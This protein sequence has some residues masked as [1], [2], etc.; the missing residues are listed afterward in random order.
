MDKNNKSLLRISESYREIER[1]Y[2]SDI[3]IIDETFSSALVSSIEYYRLLA[4]YNLQIA[5]G[6]SFL[7]RGKNTNKF[8]KA[9]TLS[10]TRQEKIN[11]IGNPFLEVIKQLYF[12][13]GYQHFF[14]FNA[15]APLVRKEH[16]Y[17]DERNIYQM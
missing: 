6:L 11:S 10:D 3:R 12:K 4:W 5:G 14:K 1:E 15:I 9:L 8:D 7:Q 2:E 13:D 16:L 17:F